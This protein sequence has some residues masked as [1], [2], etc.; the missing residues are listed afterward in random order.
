MGND[1]AGQ[2]LPLFREGKG[3]R[4]DILGVGAT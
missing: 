1:G 4:V 2:S 3:A